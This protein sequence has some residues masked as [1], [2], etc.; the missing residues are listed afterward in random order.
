MLQQGEEHVQRPCDR[1][2]HG[3]HENLEE[4]QRGRSREQGVWG[5][6]TGKIRREDH[7][8]A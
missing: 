6:T 2:K 8:G 1:R 4:D 7:V 5:E 3:E